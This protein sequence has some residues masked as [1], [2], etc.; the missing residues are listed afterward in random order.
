MMTRHFDPL[1]DRFIA[2]RYAMDI[3]PPFLF[4]EALTEFMQEGHFARH[5]RRMRALYKSRR[6]ALVAMER[7]QRGRHR[8]AGDDPAGLASWSVR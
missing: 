3:F 7:G 5:I 6:T 8:L 4:Q 1:V 2:V